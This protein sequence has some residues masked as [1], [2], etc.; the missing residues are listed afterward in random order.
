[1]LIR[2][3]VTPKTIEGSLMGVRLAQAGTLGLLALLSAM[4][5]PPT[6]NDQNPP[7]ARPNILIIVS[8]D[9]RL[10]TMGVMRKT[11]EW[12]GGGG[13]KFTR[14]YVTT[15]QCCPSRASIFSGRY[16][17]NHQVQS[18]KLASSLDTDETM[19]AYLDAAGYNTGF[20][21]KYLNGLP[22]GT[23]PP[24]FD[25]YAVR[26]GLRYVGATWNVQGTQMTR[27]GYDTQVI[28]RL[29]SRYLTEF[30]DT[31]ARPWFLYLAPLGPHGPSTPE[32]KY[33]DA[34]V[35]QRR[36]T[37]AMKESDFSDKPPFI[38]QAVDS[39]P[40]RNVTR[41]V[42]RHYRA[43][44]SVDDM[45]QALKRQLG[46]LRE[47]RRTLVIF[48]SDNGYLWRDHGIAGKSLPYLPSAR[49]PLYLRW[50][51]HTAEGVRDG[52]LV[53]NVDIAPTALDA[54]G[55]EPD[56]PMDGRSL[57]DRTWRRKR[58]LL[59][60]WIGY[61]PWA[62]MLT[63]RYQYTEYYVPD[64]STPVR[65]YYDLVADPW[66]LA[67]RYGDGDK[68]NDPDTS[69]LARRLDRD[70]RCAGTEPQAG[71]PPPCP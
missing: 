3:R 33:A 17:H 61:P 23:V 36:V 51:N 19:Q 55:I 46:R 14:A 30:E 67:N 12:L 45:V 16:A 34:S 71:G 41:M 43:M 54:A 62:S 69:A 57:L 8:D 22:I 48:V 50:P 13:V 42:P 25:R 15:P 66:Q 31:D 28:R 38:R 21:G 40:G 39:H 35:P 37:P 68:S 6:T 11:R 24:H 2:R 29:A 59:E 10:D 52:R 64:T 60:H 4:S 26:K 1:V 9:Q 20:A 56:S 70:R 44:L 49:V 27:S 18:N 65:E 47:R 53:A 7:D 5:L 58:L 63:P 32:A